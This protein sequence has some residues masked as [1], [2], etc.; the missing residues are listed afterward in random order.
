MEGAAKIIKF[1]E[2]DD[3]DKRNCYDFVKLNNSNN[4]LL[5]KEDPEIIREQ[6]NFLIFDQKKN[7]LYF[8][9]KTDGEKVLREILVFP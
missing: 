6:N 7:K 4:P 1:I 5:S 2:L 9:D 3:R 8:L